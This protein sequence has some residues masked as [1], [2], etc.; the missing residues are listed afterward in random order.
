MPPITVM[1]KPVSGAR[2]LMFKTGAD[3]RVQIAECV[4][5]K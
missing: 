5:D 1:I 2:N 4:I 3:G